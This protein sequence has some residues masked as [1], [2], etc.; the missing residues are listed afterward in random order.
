MADIDEM[1]ATI[2]KLQKTVSDQRFRIQQLE[3]EWSHTDLDRIRL[4]RNDADLNKM[5]RGQLLET[6]ARLQEKYRYAD[7]D[8]CVVGYVRDA[9]KKTFDGNCTFVDD[10]IHLLTVCARWA[11]QNGIPDDLCPSIFPKAK[12][13]LAANSQ[14][15]IEEAERSAGDTKSAAS[16]EA[17]LT[18]INQDADNG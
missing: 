3:D 2:A 8:G 5:E 16:A 4:L 15:P 6:I 9:A 11:L 10:D 14:S 1:T 13:H 12:A 17:D 18:P 7:L